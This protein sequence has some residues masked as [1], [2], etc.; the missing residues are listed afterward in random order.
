MSHAMRRVSPV[1]VLEAVQ[2]RIEV[3]TGVMC[4]TD[5]DDQESPFYSLDFA[6]SRPGRSKSMRLDVFDVWVH[7]ISKPSG[8]SQEV[9]EMVAALEEAMEQDVKLAAPFSVVRQDDMGV[10]VVK[11]DETQEWH[12]VVAY[13][14][15]VSYGLIIK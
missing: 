1:D 9:L 10:Q 12:A 3:G 14:I 13:E 11:Q 2:T 7:C 8:S 15:T 4:V 6:S 5:P